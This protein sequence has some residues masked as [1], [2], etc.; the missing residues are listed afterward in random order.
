MFYKAVKIYLQAIYVM[1]I[2]RF[3]AW[4]HAVVEYSCLVSAKYGYVGYTPNSV[5][6]YSDSFIL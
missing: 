4:F 1:D 3:T 2:E 5:I 6:F